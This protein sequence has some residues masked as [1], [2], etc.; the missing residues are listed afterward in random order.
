MPK[1]LT[2]K[3]VIWLS[4]TAV[5]AFL[6]VDGFGTKPAHEVHTPG[7]TPLKAAVVSTDIRYYYKTVPASQSISTLRCQ[8]WVGLHPDPALYPNPPCSTDLSSTYFASVTQAPNTL[9][10][11]WI[12]CIDWSGAGAIINWQGYNL[13]YVPSERKL[14]LHCYVAEPWLTIHPTMFGSAATS[15]E[16]L[17]IVPTSSMGPGTIQIVEDDRLE[18]LVGDQSTESTFATTTIS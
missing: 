3:R 12:G 11:L 6:L 1:W 13:E 17:L 8:V 5:V 16:T 9:Y 18:H 7:A 14:V 15:I 4:I 2:R 10:F